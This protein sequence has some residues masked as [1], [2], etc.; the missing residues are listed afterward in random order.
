MNKFSELY[1]LIGSL[2]TKIDLESSFNKNKKVLNR[3]DSELIE[4]RA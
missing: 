2:V 1:Q 4:I 3:H